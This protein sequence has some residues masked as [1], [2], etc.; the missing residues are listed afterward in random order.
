MAV[1]PLSQ[2]GLH[3]VPS[4]PRQRVIDK[5]T[6]APRKRASLDAINEALAAEGVTLHP[7]KGYRGL[8]AKRSVAAMLTA[9]IK[10]GMQ[11]FSMKRMQE[12]FKAIS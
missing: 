3:R 8:S 10:A 9:E 2:T 6:G 5:T 7:T 12:A 4:N 1:R 11:P